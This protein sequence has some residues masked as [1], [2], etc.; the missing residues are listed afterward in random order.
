ML[1]IMYKQ[2]I[3]LSL[4]FNKKNILL[5]GENSL[6]IRNTIVNYVPALGTLQK[7]IMN[8]CQIYFS[9]YGWNFLFSKTK[10]EA[11][12]LARGMF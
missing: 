5:L 9:Q 11:E 12:N 6:K 2:L 1:E 3:V 4:I 10:T 7:E 8:F